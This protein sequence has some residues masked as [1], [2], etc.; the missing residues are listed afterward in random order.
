MLVVSATGFDDISILCQREF[1]RWDG[2]RIGFGFFGIRMT[3]VNENIKDLIMSLLMK[4]IRGEI[5]TKSEVR[6]LDKGIEAFI[7]FRKKSHRSLR[8][9]LLRIVTKEIQR[10]K[11]N[12]GG[13]Q[14]P[15][16]SVK[17]FDGDI[18]WNLKRN[19]IAIEHL[20]RNV[21]LRLGRHCERGVT[22]DFE[23]LTNLLSLSRD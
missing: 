19:E 14:L 16:H 7:L 6:C 10:L 21:D 11:R 2:G 9:R 1:E 23:L 8:K 5:E 13:N 15:D 4:S 12:L 18:R 20:D 22:F 17:L 3:F